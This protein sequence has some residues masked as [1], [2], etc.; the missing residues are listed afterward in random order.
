MFIIM[1]NQSEPK[2]DNAIIRECDYFIYINDVQT[3]ILRI[4][5]IAFGPQWGAEIINASDNAIIMV[6][7]SHH[8]ITV[9]QFGN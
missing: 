8:E 6:Y 3:I 4:G 7:S 2:N 5:L 1:V 9:W